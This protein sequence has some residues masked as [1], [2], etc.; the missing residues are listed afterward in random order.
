MKRSEMRGYLSGAV[1]PGLRFAPSGLRFAG[2]IRNNARSQNHMQK[3]EHYLSMRRRYQPD[4]V[5]LAIVA[6]SPPESGKYFY[7]PDGLVS[8]PLF[9][10]FAKQLELK[11][12]S[13]DEGLLA[14]QA[15]GWLLVDATYE[16]VNGYS[17]NLRN[18]TI[19]RDY[20]NL[21]TDLSELAAPRVVLVKANVCRIL[22]P[23]LLG[24]GFNVINRGRSISFPSH[25]QQSKFRDQFASVVMGE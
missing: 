7:N 14:F 6:E 4:A 12:S 3:R 2:L 18:A 16:P 5:K 23:R 24:D 17:D 10:A 19:L 15:K 8:E 22:E 20:P 1:S 13:K 9:S 25:G 11:P 21:R